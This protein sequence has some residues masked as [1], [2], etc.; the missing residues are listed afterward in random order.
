M[1]NK[2]NKKIVCLAAVAVMLL[3]G[4]TVK[5]A[6]AYFTTYV[7][8]KDTN[9][10]TV[11]F[12][13]TEIA[14][15]G[16]S[17]QK[18]IIITNTGDYACFVRV[19]AIIPSEYGTVSASGE[20]WEAKDGYYEYTEVLEPEKGTKPL[21]ASILTTEGADEEFNVVAIQECTPVLYSEIGEVYAN[22]NGSEFI[23]DKK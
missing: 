9:D 12:T 17:A 16:D 5:S 2:I 14:M 18:T 3:A 13:E 22:W 7:I 11:G 1:K 15:T 19:K 8:V 21:V 23:I 6:L 10:L 4:S 20:G